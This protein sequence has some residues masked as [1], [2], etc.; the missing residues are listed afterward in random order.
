MLTG[1]MD[2]YQERPLARPLARANVR[3]TTPRN[4]GPAV[5]SAMIHDLNDNQ[6]ANTLALAV[7]FASGN[8]Q[9]SHEGTK[10]MTFQE[11]I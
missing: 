2:P 1:L 7:S 3:V 8:L 10:E 9:T 5:G 6:I 4:F 11:A